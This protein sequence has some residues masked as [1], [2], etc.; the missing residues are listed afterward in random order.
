[1]PKK[2]GTAHIRRLESGLYY[3][4]IK[5]INEANRERVKSSVTGITRAQALSTAV[6]ELTALAV[7]NEIHDE[8]LIETHIEDP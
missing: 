5:Y 8:I 7:D 6:T 1:M 2:I 3:L 4:I